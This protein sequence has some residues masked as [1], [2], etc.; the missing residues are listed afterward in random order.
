MTIA[1]DLNAARARV[2]ELE[3][4]IRC[5]PHDWDTSEPYET[6]FVRERPDRWSGWTYDERVMAMGKHRTCRLCG[7]YQKSYHTEK[8]WSEYV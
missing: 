6:T 4:K 2:R 5:C 8:G 7:L 1:D 3:T